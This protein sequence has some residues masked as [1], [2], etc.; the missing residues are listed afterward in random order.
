MN[1]PRQ[2]L[3]ELAARP[4][5]TRDRLRELNDGSLLVEALRIA[6][7]G[8]A[9]QILCDVLGFRH[10]RAAVDD[11][12]ACLD[13]PSAG[14]RSS[15]A[16]ALAAIGDGRAG[17]ALLAKME[18]PEPDEGVLRMIVAALGAVRY[19]GAIP[20]LIPLLMSSDPSMRGSAA[21][22]LGAMHAEE[23]LP[24]LHDAARIERVGYAAERLREAIARIEGRRGQG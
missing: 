12:V 22:S 20:R 23:A 3:D 1:D 13:D 4:G 10:E 7:S 15:A 19:C 2:I 11:L 17:P 16:D 18:A 9:K 21:W 6:P 24:K 5:I 8:I 14:V